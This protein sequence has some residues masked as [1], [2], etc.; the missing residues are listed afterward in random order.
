MEISATASAAATQAQA[1]SDAAAGSQDIGKDSFLKLLITQMQNQDPLSPMDNQA[2]LSQLA[3]FSALEQMQNLNDKMDQAMQ[4]GQSMNNY[5]AA[6]LIGRQVR[7][8]GDTVNLDTSGSV[9]L[10][11]FLPQDAETVALTVYDENGSIVRN[12]VTSDGAAG[13]HRVSWDG[14]ND[15]GERLDAGTYNF[16]V[17]AV[18]ADG[19]DVSATSVVD[20]LVEGVTYKNGSALLLI[21]GREVP[22]SDLLEVFAPDGQ[23]QGD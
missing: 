10:G 11:Y 4:L 22:L 9:E 5:S 19:A 16:K 8:A 3:Q 14:R 12:L 15:A 2:F 21:G 18:D 7:A 20:G 1:V 6:G 17:S 13:A 23:G